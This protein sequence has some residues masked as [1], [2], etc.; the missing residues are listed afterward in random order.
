MRL[1]LPSLLLFTFLLAGAAWSISIAV[2]ELIG[3][4]G[5]C[6][7]DI[8][9][10][11]RYA[12]A[13][14]FDGDYGSH[15][16][17]KWQ[18]ASGS[19]VQIALSFL[20]MLILWL[21]PPRGFAPYVFLWSLLGAGFIQSGAYIAFGQFIHP[22]MDWARLVNVAGG[23]WQP[24]SL[25]ITGG[26]LL[27]IAG[28]LAC[29]RLMPRVETENSAITGLPVVMT[30]YLGFSVTAVAAAF[31]VPS[32]DRLFMLFGGIGSGAL[33]MFWFLFA[34][35]PKGGPTRVLRNSTSGIAIL[36]PVI[37]I[38]AYVVLLG[39]GIHF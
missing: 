21:A 12:D 35:L 19:L 28:V 25:A 11:W 4:G 26:I 8:T 34:A 39:R 30:A 17:S 15:A 6:A 14:Y 20:A 13:M 9:C 38:A 22:G 23:G 31:F 32:D 10:T 18:I 16:V 36:M 27:V 37:I 24:K 29:R 3:H 33:F 7:I 5:H 1:S 2:H